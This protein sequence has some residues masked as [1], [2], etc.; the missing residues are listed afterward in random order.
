MRSDVNSALQEVQR[1]DGFIEGLQ[2]NRDWLKEEYPPHMNKK[3]YNQLLD[4]F[5]LWIN[6][7]SQIRN[8]LYRNLREIEKEMYSLVNDMQRYVD[9]HS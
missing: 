1:M 6:E 3:N 7:F 4:N 8:S 9:E 5:D 2:N